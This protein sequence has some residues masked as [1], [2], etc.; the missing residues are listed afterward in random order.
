[1]KS[2]FLDLATASL[3]VWGL[4]HGLLAQQ[5]A[6]GVPLAS[7]EARPVNTTVRGSTAFRLPWDNSRDQPGQ[8]A[9]EPSEQAI[10]RHP[11]FPA[12]Q[13]AGGVADQIHEHVHDYTCVLIKRERIEDQLQDFQTMRV[14]VRCGHVADDRPA[15]PFS[16]FLEFLGPPKVRGRRVLFVE[17]ENNNKMLARNGGK[18]F[19]YV[20]V[21]L[22]PLSEAATRESLVPITEMGLENMTRMLMR[23]LKENIQHDPSGTNSRLAFYR[24]AKVNERNCTRIS[25]RHPDPNPALGFS[26]ADVYVDDEFHVPIRLEAYAWPVRPSG[27]SQ[28]LFEYTYEDL[29]L[30]VGLTGADFQPSLLQSPPSSTQE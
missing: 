23:L 8:Q 27:P 1:M 17:G 6:R 25:V 19:N 24:N 12:L 5:P 3:V 9:G 29:H 10:A 18:R 26:S 21:K 4:V 15:V 28:L 14:R 11:L 2:L 13:F 20:I 7:A 30:N 22:D 16:V